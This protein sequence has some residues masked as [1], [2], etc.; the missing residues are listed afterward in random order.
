MNQLAAG[1]CGALTATAINGATVTPVAKN[2]NKLVLAIS[3]METDGDGAQRIN[4]TGG[5]QLSNNCYDIGLTAF[6]LTNFGL[7]SQSEA[8][9]VNATTH[10]P[11]PCPD[12]NNLCG[13]NVV[14]DLDLT[15]SVLT[16]TGSKTRVAKGNLLVSGDGVTILNQLYGGADT[17]PF[18]DGEQVGSGKYTVVQ[19]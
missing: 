14:G 1:T 17:G 12:P 11:D 8:F 15:N 5:L 13:R 9:T 6:R 4:T 16:V 10:G 3:G 18:T 7:P 19:H 2:G